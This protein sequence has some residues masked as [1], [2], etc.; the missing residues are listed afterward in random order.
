MTFFPIYNPKNI[1]TIQKVSIK[2]AFLLYSVCNYFFI[3]V[4]KDSTKTYLNEC[5]S[6]HVIGG[7]LGSFDRFHLFVAKLRVSKN[8]GLR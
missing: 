3:K 4:S 6:V 7:M 1:R 8:F 2:R 5:L